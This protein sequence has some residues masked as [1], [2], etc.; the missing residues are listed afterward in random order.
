MKSLIVMSAVTLCMAFAA[1]S[2]Y[3]D[4]VGNVKVQGKGTCS[5]IQGTFPLLVGVIQPTSNT[6][7]YKLSILANI[8]G[9]SQPQYIV[10]TLNQTGNATS[11]TAS[12]FNNGFLGGS[13]SGNVFPGT[14]SGTFFFDQT[15]T[16]NI[17]SLTIITGSGSNTCE[18]DFTNG[19][20]VFAL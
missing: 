2:A 17:T 13:P 14:W 5:A 4:S 9:F 20:A 19:Q 3:A 12:V 10:D 1:N 6:T 15:A 8:S 18:L 16:F 11:G 7:V